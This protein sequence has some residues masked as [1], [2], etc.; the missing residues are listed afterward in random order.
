MSRLSSLNLCAAWATAL[1]CGSLCGCFTAESD[2]GRPRELGCY[3][4]HLETQEDC[5]IRWSICWEYAD[6]DPEAE[7]LCNDHFV[8][9]V[10]ST[11]DSLFA[12][13]YGGCFAEWN[14]CNDGCDGDAACV[15]GCKDAE[16]E[17]AQW[18]DWGCLL[19]CEEFEDMC[20]DDIPDQHAVTTCRV[21]RFDCVAACYE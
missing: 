13:S 11:R 7:Q 10:E 14:D 16:L 9:C 15:L 2:H 19:A 4:R 21:E 18:Y 12:C 20:L 1:A 6:D 5:Y 17:C 8:W 3:L